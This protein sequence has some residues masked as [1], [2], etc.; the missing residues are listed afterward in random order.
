MAPGPHAD[1]QA[2]TVLMRVLRGTGPGGLAGIAP[3]REEEG[4]RVARPLLACTRAEVTAWA[5]ARGIAW[6][7]DVSNLDSGI[8]RNRLR[9]GLLPQLA[10]SYNPN[11]REALT[12]LAETARLEDDLLAR[13]SGDMLRAAQHRNRL[14]RAP[15]RAAHEALLR[16]ALLGWLRENEIAA[17]HELLAR[18]AAF[19]ID[20]TTGQQLSLDAANRLHAAG[21]EI[22]LVSSVEDAVKPVALAVP[23]EA[24]FLGQRYVARV[25]EG[26]SKDD[27]KALCTP[28][29][30]IFD[31]DRL[32][33]ALTLRTRR[34]GDA[35]V[36]LGMRGHR[37]L[38]DY[39]VD[40][41][42]AMPDRARV[43]L[44]E[45]G[46]ELAWVVGHAPGAHFAV[47]AETR[48]LASVEVIDAPE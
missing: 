27:V 48:R 30:Q 38:Q 6:R 31:A 29:Y 47:T 5:E 45:S 14:A 21:E 13:L 35:F 16:R 4:I 42:V 40:R 36:P 10:E 8:V 24:V 3:V 39:F 15:L 32:G 9:H 7:E 34:D 43:P 2:E 12:R 20:A 44:L 37:K 26:A 33:N 25:L 23:G 19:C 17:D 41:R 11:V 1:D 28:A 22:L 18:V 46:G